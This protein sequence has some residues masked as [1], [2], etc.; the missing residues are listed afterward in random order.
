MVKDLT[1][2][3]EKGESLGMSE[4]STFVYLELG[5]KIDRVFNDLSKKANA[6]KTK[7]EDE[8]KEL[9]ILVN[10]LRAH[11][12]SSGVEHSLVSQNESKSKNYIEFSGKA[13]TIGGA[14]SEDISITGVKDSQICNV[15]MIQEGAIPVTVKSA[16]CAENKITIT[17]SGDPSDDHIISYLI[18]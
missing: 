9:R 15:F 3:K 7:I 5:A 18:I 1:K 2:F 13:T 4:A 17:F 10:S 14:A 16:I 11:A 6:S 12:S 8:I